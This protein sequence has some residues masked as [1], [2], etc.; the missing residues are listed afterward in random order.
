MDWRAKSSSRSRSRSVSAMDWR[1]GN[2]SR[3]RP[4]GSQ[5][6]QAID[7][8]DDDIGRDPKE[9]NIGDFVRSEAVISEAISPALGMESL[10]TT[11][12]DNT[13]MGASTRVRSATTS[14][15]STVSKER[16]AKQM[17]KA[18]K[19]AA[20]ADLF[21]NPDNQRDA[22]SVPFFFGGRN[23]NARWEMGA[24]QY[25]GA[26]ISNLGSVAGIGDYAGHS[27][28]QHP[29]YGF[30]PRLV[31]KTSFDHSVERSRSRG[32]ANK[33]NAAGSSKPVVR[34]DDQS[35]SV[36]SIQ[37]ST[38]SVSGRKRPFRED[39]SPARPQMRI[40][41]SAEERLAV[42]LS[43][44]IPS[45]LTSTPQ[46]GPSSFSFSVPGQSSAV[47]NGQPASSIAQDL[48]DELS[49]QGV[50]DGSPSAA[51]TGAVNSP[52]NLGSTGVP[53]NE[54]NINGVNSSGATDL[55]AIMNMFYNSDASMQNQQHS[56]T[57]VNPNHVFGSMGSG[58]PAGMS[59]NRRGDELP[60]NSDESSWTYS[61]STSSPAVTP[62][63]AS[64]MTNHQGNYQPSPLT[65]ETWQPQ[66][67]HQSQPHP[68]LH[69]QPQP[70]LHHSASA[71]ITR[72]QS[73]EDEFVIPHGPSQNPTYTAARY[74]RSSGPQPKAPSKKAS[75]APDPV[76]AS[77]ASTSK[78]NTPSSSRKNTLESGE[79]S[80]S[81]TSSS[82]GKVD[83]AAEEPEAP[84]TCSNCKTSKTPLWRRDAE[85][86]PL[87]EFSSL[88]I[89]IETLSLLTHSNFTSF[90]L[91][92]Y[93]VTLAVSSTS[94]MEKSDLFL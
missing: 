67:L 4:A 23:T 27:G 39:P 88:P 81:L 83:G 53:S 66:Q 44:N 5:R 11:F 25:Y 1:S 17:Q 34:F 29:E 38:N 72:R 60:L 65:M 28:N 43:R 79:P 46:F 9:F 51:G 49:S 82:P 45:F 78:T 13:D 92:R 57:H 77:S 2:R 18:F 32:P 55:D 70:V 84:T 15:A 42:G 31:R 19:E 64:A 6:L 8:D 7:D 30:L 87:C 68:Q 22:G 56:F 71:P 90:F 73:A 40:P 80:G 21:G 50:S 58:G 14:G 24:A 47:Q 48:F 33:N 89:E 12:G 37:P 16:K 69:S 94:F 62:P 3:S 93:Q 52:S 61:P 75:R 20:H 74:G 91:S 86:R 26:P 35:N 36:Q 63:P 59:P 10:P 54:V 85:M 76:T 41:V